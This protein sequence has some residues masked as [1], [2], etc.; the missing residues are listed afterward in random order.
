MQLLKPPLSS[1]HWKV[2]PVLTAGEAEAG[3]RAVARVRRLGC[4]GGVRRRVSMVQVK[5][6]RGVGVAGDVGG[7]H[8]KGVAAVRQTQCKLSGWC[9][10]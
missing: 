10:R 5:L 9:S 3:V 4:D 2:D 1:W 7:C 6:A 8:H